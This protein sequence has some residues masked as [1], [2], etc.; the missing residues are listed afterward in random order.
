M[1]NTTELEP[2]ATLSEQEMESCRADDLQ[3][4]SIVVGL[5]SSVFAMGVLLYLLIW[6]I[7]WTG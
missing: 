2:K 1:T 6:W 5:M 3:A 7:V 4:G